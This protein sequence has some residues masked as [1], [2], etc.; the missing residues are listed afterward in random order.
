VGQ[1]VAYCEDDHWMRMALADA[2]K[3]AGSVEPNP[4]VGAA[5]V[6]DGL[7]GALA[8]H[9]RFGGPH[10][11]VLALERA[12][13]HARGATLY[14]TLEPCCHFGKTPPCTGAVIAA[15]ITRVVAAMSDPFPEV[16]G[17]GLAA[18]EAAGISVEVGCQAELARE[19]NAPYLKRLCTRMPFVTAKWAMTFDGKVATASGD[20][21]WISSEISRHLVHELRGRMD[22]IVVG[23]GTVLADD[24]QLTARIA[25]PPRRPARIILDSEARLPE[26]SLLARS[27]R[28]VPVLIAVTNRANP[29]R[30]DRLASLGC[31]VVTFAGN[32]QVPIVPLLE[33]LSRRGMTNLLVEG[34]GH[35]LGSF[36]DQG[37]VDAID[38][39]IAP[40]IEG[41]DHAR[42]PVRG[43]GHELMRD[44]IRLSRVELTEIGGDFRFRCRVPQLWR[45]QAGFTD[46]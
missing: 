40:F 32:A 2:A 13:E 27:A 10:A 9:E 15:G 44:A 7:L 31:E 19:L 17:R 41:G 25:D 26:K 8:H 22:G 24:P 37:Q 46:D 16:S 21:R 45:K 5:V 12:G 18:L 11:E 20:S 38:I 14:V 43:R 29:L 23:I 30:V 42:T 39:F 6:R 33:E 36:I 28:E 34:G 1:S 4:L 35:V 3:G